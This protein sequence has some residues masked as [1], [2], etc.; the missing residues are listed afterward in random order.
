MANG[1][2]DLVAA[3]QIVKDRL[4]IAEV[5]GRYVSLTPA[6]SN[7]L[8]A[9]CPF[10]SETKPSFFVDLTRGAFH[11]FGCQ[12][13]GDIFEFY[14]KYHG[15]GFRESLEQL[16][17]EAGVSLRK[18]QDDSG[19]GARQEERKRFLRQ[20]ELAGKYFRSN[21]RSPQGKI[22]REYIAGRCLD[23][24]LAGNFELGW[25][26]NDWQA[27]SNFLQRAGYSRE[28]GIEAGLL[29]KNDAGNIY[30]FFRSRLI[31]PIKNLA[32]QIIAFGGRIIG[33]E[34]EAAKYINS[35][36]SS[37]Y[38]K[39]EH[40]YG[41]AQARRGISAQKSVLLTEGYMDVLTL[42]Q[43][44]YAN[45]CGVLGT[46]LT[47]EHIL[48]LR[49]LA[50]H[51]ELIFDGDRAGREAAMKSAR[52]LLL[53]GLNC[54]IVTLPD[55]PQAKDIDLLLKNQ[56]IKTFEDLRAKAPD[57]LNYCMRILNSAFSP[58]DILA[59]V[60]DFLHELEQPEFVSGYISKLS[61]G[62]GLE[63]AAIRK[64]MEGKISI[65]GSRIDHEE[66]SSLE[67]KRDEGFLVFALRSPRHIAVLERHGLGFVLESPRGVA[68]WDKLCS[69][70]VG[71][72]EANIFEE[73]D[74]KDRQ[75]CLRCR[76]DIPV[77]DIKAANQECL[78]L[79]SRIEQ[80]SQDKNRMAARQALA[81]MREYPAA[82][83]G[84]D[85]VDDMLRAYDNAARKRIR[86]NS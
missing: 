69:L 13:S 41:L 66:D 72:V 67:W 37:I 27:L 56:G 84:H 49:G 86:K 21:L 48:K 43:F 30:D 2:S 64:E 5:V 77:T 60:K 50:S 40:L 16:A 33:D 71:A 29:K 35:P 19:S 76:L 4:N 11:C 32:G 34:E 39:K 83:S 61:Q 12:A 9:P 65:R 42:H 36:D 82:G 62:L 74:E 68:L 58:R 59:W 54:R 85:S 46:A 18:F 28:Q 73:L 7:R 63:E 23:E 81:A 20:Y 17:L 57:G 78:S 24:K 6:G 38:K 44:G 31:F 15:L 1:A 75:F 8:K 22:C 47:H 45:A 55:D 10:H 3:K 26:L 25:S 51:L 53:Y 80:I 52:L 79:C 70:D 14:G